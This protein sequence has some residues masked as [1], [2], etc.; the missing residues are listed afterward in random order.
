MPRI[1]LQ[2]LVSTRQ[3]EVEISPGAF[4]QTA[5]ATARLMSSV[6]GATD[7][8]KKQFDKAQDLSNR[9]TI[10]E[11]RRE[12]RDAQGTFQNEMLEGNVHPSEWGPLWEERLVKVKESLNL[13]DSKTPPVVRRT[14]NEDFENFAGSSFIQISG[15][16]LKENQRRAKQNFDRDYQFNALNKNH[17]AN[18]ALVEENRDLLG[19]DFADDTLQINGL[20]RR[21]DAMERSRMNDPL[22]HPARVKSGEWGLSEVQQDEE[23]RAAKVQASRL[24]AEGLS[25]IRQSEDAGTIKDE[26]DL[27]ERLEDD[28]F[29]SKNARLAY[30]RNYNETKPLTD[31]ERYR[32]IDAVNALT[33]L[34]YTEEYE[35][36]YYKVLKEFE[37]LG[38][39]ENKPRVDIY[40]LYPDRFSVE[41][42]KKLSMEQQAEDKKPLMYVADKLIKERAEGIVNTAYNKGKI[43]EPTDGVQLATN[44]ATRQRLEEEMVVVRKALSDSLMGYIYSF[45]KGEKPTEVDLKKFMDATANQ[46]I[47]DTRRRLRSSNPYA[48]PGGDT[49]GEYSNPEQ[50]EADRSKAM[51]DLWLDNSNI[52][53]L[54]P[55]E[56][57]YNPPE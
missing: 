53:L 35:D 49:V 17:D 45:P 27:K 48:V 20:M 8:I 6:V 3:S 13:E 39:R 25:L 22:G 21:N 4:S 11:K 18:D 1:P 33:P 12:I 51:M 32:L 46:T 43:L 26:E 31:V 47:L 23:I 34:R 9:S 2:S 57:D 54:L 30:L 38:R 52:P 14:L 15:A 44:S 41:R 16:A 24:E 40:N 37:A 29:I 5:Q 42:G 28:P 50:T 7:M 10:S 19:D 55:A 56:G 36:E